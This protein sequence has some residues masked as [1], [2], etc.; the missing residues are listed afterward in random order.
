M[1][2]A[3][4]ACPHCGAQVLDIDVRC[5]ACGG[6]LTSTGAQRRVGSIVL[7][8]R[9]HEARAHPGQVAVA[10]KMRELLGL[11]PGAR[12]ASSEARPRDAGAGSTGGAGA[13]SSDFVW[14]SQSRS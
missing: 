7:D 14:M 1:N 11:K 8:A 4:I 9:V 10:E 6:G 3:A 2:D 13:R 5:G 12:R